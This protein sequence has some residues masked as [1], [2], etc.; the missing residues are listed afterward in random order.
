MQQPTITVAGY[1]G[2]DKELTREEFFAHWSEHVLQLK[3]LDYNREWV[4]KV[5]A[6][7][8]QVKAK[9]H[10]EFDR[11]HLEQTEKISCDL[12]EDGYR[13]NDYGDDDECSCGRGDG[14]DCDGHEA[15]AIGDEIDG[16][17]E[18]ANTKENQS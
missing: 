17:R 14:C 13:G 11:I 18:A 2:K 4:F 3:R 6:M 10:E 8:N 7:H 5:E 15:K 16:K 1:F 12:T 9:C